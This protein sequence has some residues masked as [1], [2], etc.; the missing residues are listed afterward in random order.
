VAYHDSDSANNGG[1]YRAVSVDMENC[2][3]SGG[4]YNVGWTAA[5][6]W[7]KYSVKA[8][9]DGIYS[10]GLRVASS[11]NA[12]TF[13]IEIDG[14]NVTGALMV[15]NTGGWQTWQTLTKTNIAISAGQHV[16]RL[17]LDSPGDNGTVGNY[18]HLTFTATSTNPPPVVLQSAPNVVGNFADEGGAVINQGAKTVTAIKNP[19]TRY[20]RLRSTV[21]TRILNVQIVSTNV[22]LTYE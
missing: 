2:A 15:T 16:V 18:N 11:G 14:Q 12:G 20:Y 13:H 9:V 17:A 3:D 4:G 1:Q 5:E 19:G 22:V 6:E 7:L 10:L 21:P 8:M